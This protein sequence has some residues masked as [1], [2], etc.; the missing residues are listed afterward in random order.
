MLNRLLKPLAWTSLLAIVFVTISPIGLRPPDP[1]P[2]NLDRAA[3][4]AVMAVLFTVAYPRHVV[5]C[6]IALILGAGSI[7]LL[8]FLSPTRHAHLDDAVV[9][10]CGALAG[11]L[12]GWAF[13]IVRARRLIPRQQ[14]LR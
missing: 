5:R 4:F 13:N 3:A 12:A 9:K 11:V 14:H 6:A 2:V 8:Q 1:L 7:E 10:A